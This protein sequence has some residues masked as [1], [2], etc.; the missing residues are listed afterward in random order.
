MKIPMQFTGF[1]CNK[2]A[3]LREKFSKMHC[4]C[5]AQVC[6]NKSSYWNMSSLFTYHVCPVA[7]EWQA[8]HCLF[9]PIVSS[10][11]F[12]LPLCATINLLAHSFLLITN[13]STYKLYH[14]QKTSHIASDALYASYLTT[15]PEVL[16][17]CQC[18]N[19]Q[20]IKSIHHLPVDCLCLSALR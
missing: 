11:S 5:E 16:F 20:A 15:T 6:P 19:H 8:H 14:S 3:M 10:I 9:F 1:K 18:T 7:S 2:A 13:L 12:S 17:C 4:T